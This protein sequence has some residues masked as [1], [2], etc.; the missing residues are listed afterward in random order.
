MSD[1]IKLSTGREI[2]PNCGIVGIDGDLVMYEG[3]DGHLDYQ[4]GAGHL[5]C[6]EVVEICDVVMGRWNLLRDECL[7]K[8]PNDLYQ[9]A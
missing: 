3:Y 9:E 6:G 8:N 1:T 4:C 7:R 5:T 2:E